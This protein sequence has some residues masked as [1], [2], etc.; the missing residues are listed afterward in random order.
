[1]A[2]TGQSPKSAPSAGQDRSSLA[3]YAAD[4]LTPD[5]AP[6]YARSREPELYRYYDK[7]EAL[8]GQWLRLCEPGAVVLD[9]PCGTGRFSQLVADCGHRLVRA[10]LSHQMVAH[11]RQL[12]PNH[13]ALGDL[14][15][16]LADPPLAAGSVEIVLVW[17][18]FH[19]CRTPEDRETVLRQARRLAKRYVIIS[20]YNRASMTY[21]TKR[22]L[23][24]LLLRKPKARRAIWTGELI[25]IAERVGLVP[26]QVHHYRRGISINSAACFAV[27][28][29]LGTGKTGGDSH[30]F[31]TIVSVDSRLDGGV[32]GW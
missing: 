19:H 6:K 28:G 26:L 7:E 27:R 8:V 21:W 17:R 4:W 12:G 29:K 3:K 5:A 25:R 24:K 22:V 1:M 14:C 9:L 30:L 23:R 10:D 20:Y 16:D 11:A 31:E 2:E 15:C 32:L 13:H 18:L